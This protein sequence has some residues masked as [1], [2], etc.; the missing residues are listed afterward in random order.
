M[1]QAKEE[2]AAVGLMRSFS[3]SGQMVGH[4]G[5]TRSRVGSSNQM[6]AVSV[7]AAMSND[8]SSVGWRNKG[9]HMK[10]S[11][12]SW[13]VPGACF[14]LMSCAT[15]PSASIEQSAASAG[16]QARSERAA[17]Y[18]YR[19]PGFLGSALAHPFT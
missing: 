10:Q 17:I 19:L 2:A 6:E 12:G 14:F 13:C 7:R 15:V 8:S 16:F 11:V 9:G 1:E 4:A 3:Q 18:I 5:N